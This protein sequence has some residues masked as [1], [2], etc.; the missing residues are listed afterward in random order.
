MKK[1]IVFLLLSI[2]LM[3]LLSSCGRTRANTAAMYTPAPITPRPTFDTQRYRTED[4]IRGD[5]EEE[6]VIY[7]GNRSNQYPSINSEYEIVTTIVESESDNTTFD[8]YGNLL[9]V[10]GNSSSISFPST[11]I[12]GSGGGGSS[13][14]G[15]VVMPAKTTEPEEPSVIIY[16]NPDEQKNQ[17]IPPVV[18]VAPIAPSFSSPSWLQAVNFPWRLYSFDGGTYLGKLV[19]SETD[20]ESVWNPNGKYGSTTDINSIWNSYSMF[21]GSVSIYSPFN[22]ASTSPPRVV[23]C[24]G[25]LV[26]R[27]TANTKMKESLTLDELKSFLKSNRQ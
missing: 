20:I 13:S 25:K 2:C 10:F 8:L 1:N 6:L 5:I 12:F 19:T 24:T 15:S 14:S 11:T 27:V 16:K 4:K 9:N 23:D 18:T 26:C 7:D 21:G 3:V 17:P 22:R